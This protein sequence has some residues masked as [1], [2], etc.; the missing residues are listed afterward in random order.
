MFII[1][2]RIAK[3]SNYPVI[4]L[5]PKILDMLDW[6]VGEEVIL[7]LTEKQIIIERKKDA[8]SR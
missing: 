7:T 3:T 8:Q 2:K 6:K 5:P 1:P 4:F